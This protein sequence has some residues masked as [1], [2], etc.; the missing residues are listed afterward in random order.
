MTLTALEQAARNAILRRLE[1]AYERWTET[2]RLLTEQGEY[3]QA[4]G[5]HQMALF[6]LRAL[7]AEDLNHKPKGLA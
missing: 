7:D 5:A 3:A 4:E 1:Q 6:V 2:E